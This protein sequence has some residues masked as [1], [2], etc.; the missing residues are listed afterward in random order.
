MFFATASVLS[1]LGDKKMT[2][3]S[4]HLDILSY[5]RLTQK[6]HKM[7]NHWLF[8]ERMK[9]ILLVLI[10]AVVIFILLID[11]FKSAILGDIKTII[12]EI[13]FIALF[14]YSIVICS[15]QILSN[16]RIKL[17]KIRTLEAVI[18][19]KTLTRSR[20]T[21]NRTRNCFVGAKLSDDITIYA[22]CDVKLYNKVKIN[23]TIG[24]FFEIGD[25]VMHVML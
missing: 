2:T 22:D 5:K 1:V 3:Y 25:G 15:K 6:E 9:K 10:E 8:K 20:E 19:E 11:L 16:L 24:L 12:V 14:V 18:T 21:I 13:L 4:A 17:E 23:E 7:L